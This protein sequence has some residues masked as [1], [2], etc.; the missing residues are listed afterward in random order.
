MHAVIRTGGKQY[1]V[2]EGDVILVEK[3]VGAAGDA[4]TFD[5]VLMLSDDSGS[6]VGTP[7]VAKASVKGTVADQA[8]A[9]KITVFKKLRRKNHRKRQG[10]RQDLTVVRITGIEGSTN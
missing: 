10:H 3:L 8:R 7:L 6:V 1:R 4:V 2:A 5:E 9:P